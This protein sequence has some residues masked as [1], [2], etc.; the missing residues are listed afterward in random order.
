MA[1]TM[2]M[3]SQKLGGTHKRKSPPPRKLGGTHKRKSPPP[4]VVTVKC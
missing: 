4:R 1:G 2:K 3:S